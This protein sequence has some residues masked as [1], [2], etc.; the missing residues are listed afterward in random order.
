MLKGWFCCCNSLN[1]PI[2]RSV[3]IEVLTKE[4]EWKQIEM[5]NSVKAIVLLNLQSYAGGRNIWGKG[6][7]SKREIEK[8]LIEPKLNDGLFEVVG[9]RT[10]YHTGFVMVGLAHCIR[11]GQGKAARIRAH[12][13]KEDPA[14]EIE[15][16]YMQI[17]GEPWKQRIPTSAGEVLNIDVAHRGRSSLLMNKR[18]MKEKDF[19][20]PSEPVKSTTSAPTEPAA[21]ATTQ[22]AAAKGN[23]K[24]SEQ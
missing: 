15:S 13:Q 5:P 16:L 1:P 8:G 3:E 24:T 22:E 7:L 11:L 14:G 2:N 20:T 9:F 21:S 12:R 19:E 4:D 10:G 23:N 6:R 17:D 18:K